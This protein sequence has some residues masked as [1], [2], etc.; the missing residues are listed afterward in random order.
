MIDFDESLTDVLEIFAVTGG[1]KKRDVV[2]ERKMTDEVR[3]LFRTAKEA[4]L[5]SRLDHKAFDVVNN[6]AADR[7][8]VMRARWVLTW[9]STC[10]A[11]A[12]V[13]WVFKVRT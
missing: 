5:Q 1:D 4:E 3:K 6:K 8:R 13:S 11:K 9:R 2:N 12:S 10:K 7:D